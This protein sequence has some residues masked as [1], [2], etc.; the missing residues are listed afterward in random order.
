MLLVVNADLHVKAESKEAIRMKAMLFTLLLL[1]MM[2]LSACQPLPPA[3]PAP[4][5]T[6]APKTAVYIPDLENGAAAWKSAQCGA[7]HG[8]L[9]LG[10][11]G[12]QLAATKLPYTPFLEMVR[13]AVPP[14]PAY[15]EAS[16][17]GQTVY[18]IYAWVRTQLPPAQVAGAPTSTPTGALPDME[19]MMSMT[20]WTCKKC[21]TCHGAFAQGS[22]T[23]PALAGVSESE[24]TV[25]DQM[26][27]TAASIPEHGVENIPD[28]IFDR[29]YQ[30]LK[31]GCLTSECSQ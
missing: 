11:I 24:Q 12:P 3:A 1:A 7:C 28:D 14:K 29:L 9:A 26:R 16:L 4:V 21:S 31:M 30:W 22:A 13:S 27:S 19:Q 17:P 23:A 6:V 5:P 10:G 2:A 20:I 25:L 18:D 15:D 8:P